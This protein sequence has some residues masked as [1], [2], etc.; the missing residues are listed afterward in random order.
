[1]LGLD[2]CFNFV[3]LVLHSI[4]LCMHCISMYCIVPNPAFGCHMNKT[5]LSL[6]MFARR[7]TL[8]TLA[9]CL[10]FAFS[11]TTPT[12]FQHGTCNPYDVLY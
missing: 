1:M 7:L 4:N 11:T 2:L 12:V 8:A 5:N 9:L 6:K 3:A 10:R